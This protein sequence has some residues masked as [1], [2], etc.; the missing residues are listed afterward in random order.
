MNKQRRFF[1]SVGDILRSKKYREG[2]FFGGVKRKDL[3]KQ[4]KRCFYTKINP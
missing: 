3:F 2:R 1:I 4:A